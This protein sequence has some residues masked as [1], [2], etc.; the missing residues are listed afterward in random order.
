[1]TKI[2]CIF[3][4]CINNPYLLGLCTL[5]AILTIFILCLVIFPRYILDNH[6][7][8]IHPTFRPTQL[9]SKNNS[10]YFDLDLLMVQFQILYHTLYQVLSE[11]FNSATVVSHNLRFRKFN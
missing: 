1:M 4:Y 8:E 2:H 10:E 9:N 3:N 5:L 11:I 6:K 7:D